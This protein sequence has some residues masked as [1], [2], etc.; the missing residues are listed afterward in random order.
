L[1]HADHGHGHADDVQE[2]SDHAGPA[3]RILQTGAGKKPTPA[4][5]A[6]PSPTT[7]PT[8][9]HSLPPR[10]V[11]GPI[12]PRDRVPVLHRKVRRPF[13]CSG[14]GRRFPAPIPIDS[15]A[16]SRPVARRGRRG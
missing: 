13:D 3:V 6:S 14:A 15:P 8:N 5:T 7:A 2:H 9:H 12:V 11:M 10:T 4:R 16:A 1:N